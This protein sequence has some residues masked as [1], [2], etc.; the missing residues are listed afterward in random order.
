MGKINVLLIDDH[1]TGWYDEDGIQ[2]I[3]HPELD[4]YFRF[5]WIRTMEDC[6]EFLALYSALSTSQPLA[7]GNTGLP[8]DIMIFDYALT[9]PNDDY[10]QKKGAAS[11]I[12]SKLTRLGSEQDI[13]IRLEDKSLPKT[14][15]NSGSDKFGCFVGGMLSQS[16]RDHPCGAVPVTA[17]NQYAF[18]DDVKVFKWLNEHHFGHLYE[19]EST[20]S[21]DV[22]M[23][24]G[25]G[26]KEYRNRL[27]SLATGF[28][29]HID[30][31]RLT[32]LCE[33][34][35]DFSKPLKLSSRYGTRSIPI[36]GLFFDWEEE[37][38]REQQ[39]NAWA[40]NSI[41]QIFR[42]NAPPEFVAGLR[43]ADSYFRLGEPD[44]ETYID[45]V[46]VETEIDYR[47]KLRELH[48]SNSPLTAEEKKERD[49]IITQ[50]DLSI[51][52]ELDS[53]TKFRAPHRPAIYIGQSES[54]ARWA[55]LCLCVLVACRIRGYASDPDQMSI[56]TDQQKL[57]RKLADP[58]PADLG[59]GSRITM[60]LKRQGITLSQIY[61]TKKRQSDNGG[62][63]AG[64]GKWLRLLA[65]AEGLN[66]QFPTWLKNAPD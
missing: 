8:P 19:L 32:E 18:S 62:I 37:R 40:I 1:P 54:V 56:P 4:E 7:V 48:F 16:F 5:H 59:S 39:I 34:N 24:I 64:E 30:L 10:P 43:L 46:N 9:H 63:R 33:P 44:E 29:V 50:L 66:V 60:G 53:R 31:I 57:V 17:A 65:R 25:L 23:I 52:D 35:I 3:W 28:S 27:V 20:I 41:A 58:L 11:D 22:R 36:G 42:G 14:K 2:D 13:Q 6:K 26:L 12:I 47:F 61:Q 55:I 15:Y 49:D 51:E 45:E 21:Q 38:N